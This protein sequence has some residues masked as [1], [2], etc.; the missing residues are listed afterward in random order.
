MVQVTELIKL[1]IQEQGLF[2]LFIIIFFWTAPIVIITCIGY[3]YAN[4]RN[5]DRL[6]HKNNDLENKLKIIIQTL[7]RIE[8]ILKGDYDTKGLIHTVNELKEK[9]YKE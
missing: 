8:L 7:E 2:T 1:I 9:V 5:N 3:Y 4:K 6:I